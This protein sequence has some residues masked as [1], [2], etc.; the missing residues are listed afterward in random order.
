ML[1][2]A[3]VCIV[4]IIA[5]LWDFPKKKECYSSS[6]PASSYNGNSNP[7]YS[8]N[9]GYWPYYFYATPYEYKNSGALPPGMHTRMTGWYPGYSTGTGW[10]FD[11]RPGIHYK[12]W[13]RNRWVK[14]NS[15]R[16]FINN[17]TSEDR[18]NDF[19]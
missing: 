6:P 16:Y 11:M 9:I 10:K 7:Y 2:V 17:G 12:T 8:V 14:K 1:V 15:N 19:L 5:L 18:R 4:I 13:P 3:L